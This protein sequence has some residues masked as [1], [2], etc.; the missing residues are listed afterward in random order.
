MNDMNKRRIEFR[1]EEDE[2]QDL[3]GLARSKGMTVSATIRYLARKE[4]K[5]NSV[6]L[7]SFFNKHK[8]E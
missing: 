7:C 6:D 4:I 1:L 3:R 5:E 2:Y 8:D